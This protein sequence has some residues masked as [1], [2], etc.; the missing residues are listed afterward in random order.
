MKKIK[1]QKEN[2]FFYLFNQF[3]FFLIKFFPSLKIFGVKYRKNILFI[4]KISDI[5]IIR[6]YF[7]F[8]FMLKI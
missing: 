6:N 2:I 8:F 7:L 5:I 1:N 3:F 4:N